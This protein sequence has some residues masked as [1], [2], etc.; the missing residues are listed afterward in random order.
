MIDNLSMSVL[1]LPVRM[2]KSLTVDEILQPK[3][4]NL[5]IY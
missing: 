3:Y 4:M 1:A 5:F 2:L